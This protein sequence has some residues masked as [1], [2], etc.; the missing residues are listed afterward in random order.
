LICDKQREIVVKNNINKFDGVPTPY[1]KRFVY[2][3]PD[4]KYASKSDLY[5][6]EWGVETINP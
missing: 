5:K 3:L 4:G 2:L 1:K 6:R